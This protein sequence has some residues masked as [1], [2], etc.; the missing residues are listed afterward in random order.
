[1]LPPYSKFALAHVPYAGH[2]SKLILAF[3]I[4]GPAKKDLVAVRKMDGVE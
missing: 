1:M 4:L 2:F 3:A